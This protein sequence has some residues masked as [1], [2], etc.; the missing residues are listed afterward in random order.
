MCFIGEI[1]NISTKTAIVKNENSKL[2]QSLQIKVG[3]KVEQG[4]RKF[5]RSLRLLQ[6]SNQA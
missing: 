3:K 5:D 1:L 4:F 2:P 6:I